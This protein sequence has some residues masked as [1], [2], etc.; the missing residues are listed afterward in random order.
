[1]RPE[2]SS[3]TVRRL[4]TYYRVLRELGGENA[5]V[6]SSR[7][8]AERSGVTPAQVRKDLSYFGNFG[9]RGLGY[10]IRHLMREIRTILG[11]DRRWRVGLVGAGNVGSALFSYGP[12]R[13]QGF[14]IVAIFDSEPGKIGRQWSGVPISAMESFAEVARRVPMDIVVLATPAAAAQE[15]A[16]RVVAAGVKAILNF[17][18]RQVFVPAG[19]TLRNVDVSIEIETLSFA[20]NASGDEDGDE[21]A[22]TR[23]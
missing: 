3:S 15:V 18:P 10:D 20:L 22:T 16:D 17:A 13:Q 9:K 6:A 1:M 7:L 14:D 11:L 19:I 12:F 2:I 5:R 21:P 8:L 4:S 23:R